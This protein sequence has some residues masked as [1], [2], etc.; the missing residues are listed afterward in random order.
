MKF[1]KFFV[2]PIVGILLLSCFVIPACAGYALYTQE[3]YSLEKERDTIK[4]WLQDNRHKNDTH[5]KKKLAKIEKRLKQIE[6]SENQRKGPKNL[7]FPGIGDKTA[8]KPVSNNSAFENLKKDPITGLGDKTTSKPTSNNSAFDLPDFFATVNDGNL[9]YVGIDNVNNKNGQYK[10]Y[11][12]QCNIGQYNKYLE[13]YIQKLGSYPFRLTEHWAHDWRSTSASASEVWLFTYTGSKSARTF[14]TFNV[15]NVNVN[16]PTHVNI[17]GFLNGQ[18]GIIK[19][20]VY[21]T[22]DLTYDDRSTSGRNSGSSSSNSN[23]SVYSTPNTTQ[24][25]FRCNKCHGSG[26]I[27]CGWCGGEGKTYEY[28]SVNTYGTQGELNRYGHRSSG[29]TRVAHTCS[30]CH[31][32]GSVTCPQCDGRGYTN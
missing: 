26:S 13:R 3:K 25:Q 19:M 10:G 2:Y 31:G 32:S 11:T 30:K 18:E 12:Y 9:R 17:T 7:T 14:N 15:D 27:A 6:A 16:Y 28:V 24:N 1:H 22:N 8:S 29:Q 4:L 23:H 5:L 20:Y 21:V